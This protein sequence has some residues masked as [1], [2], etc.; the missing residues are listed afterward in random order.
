MYYHGRAS[1]SPTAPRALAVCDRCGFLYNHHNLKWQYQW[2][3]PRLQ[4]LK[5]LVCDG[6]LDVPQEQLRTLL[7]PPDPVPIPDPRPE[8]YAVMV[9]SY[10]AT[11][12]SQDSLGDYSGQDQ[13]TTESSDNLILEIEVTP[14]PNPENPAI[15]SS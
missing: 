8:N 10:V 4:N 13:L 3:G 9:N 15:Y 6:C 2:V 1:I 14:S 7:L 12:G 11:Q 5:L